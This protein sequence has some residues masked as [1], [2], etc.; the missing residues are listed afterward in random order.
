MAKSGWCQGPP[1]ARIHHTSCRAFP[2]IDNFPSPD[3]DAR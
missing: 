1:G 3:G 2:F